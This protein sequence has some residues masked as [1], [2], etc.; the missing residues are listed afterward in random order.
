MATRVRRRPTDGQGSKQVQNNGQRKTTQRRDDPAPLIP[1]LARRVREVESRVSQQGQG[2][3]DEPNEV[4]R[5][6]PAHAL[7]ARP[8]HARTPRSRRRPAPTC[9][10]ASTA[11][12]R[13]SRRSRPGTRA[14]STLLDAERQ[15]RS[16]RAADAPRLAPRVGRRARR[17]G[18]R[19]HGPRAAATRRPGRR[20]RPGRSCRSRC[21][22]ARSPT[23]S[24][25]P[26]SAA[27]QQRLPPEPPRRLG[28]AQP[29]LPGLRAGRRRRGRLDGP[30][31][32]RRRSTA[33][34]RPGSQ[35]MVH[36]SRFLE[37]VREGHRTFL[38]ADE[39]G[40]GKTAQSVLA[41]SVADA[42]PMLAV[43]PNVVKINW[44]REVERWTPQRRVTVIH[45]DGD[46]VDA[47]ADVF[48]VNYEILDRHF[49]VARRRF[50]FRSMVVDE[51][52]FIKN[53]AS[54]RSQQVLA[55]GDR[56][57]ASTPVATRSCSPSPARRSSTT[58][59]TS[60]RSGASSAGSR[61]SKPAAE[62]LRRARRHR[63]HARRPRLLPRGPRAPSSTWGSCAAARSMSP[64]TCPTSAS[65]TS[66][67]SSTTSSAAR[68]AR[69]SGPSGGASPSATGPCSAR[70]DGRRGGRRARRRP[71]C[72]GS[73]AASCRADARPRRAPTTSSRW[74]ASIGQAKAA[75]AADYAVQLS[76]SV[77]K[78]VFFAKHIDVMDAAERVLAEAGLR[79]V[80]VRGDQTTTAAPGGHRRVPEG[81]RASRSRSA[82]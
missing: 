76:H 34:R 23:R 12:R 35:L 58:S 55:L 21:P 51:A 66:P 74:C 65:P 2:Q 67:S 78:V 17:G 29:A 14:C 45:G 28:P 61:A 36:Q 7:G 5:R 19:H 69:P 25:R 82:R 11:S 18:P 22:R 9:S 49:G 73:R 56:L 62:I 72:A 48:V 40:L 26:T 8:G 24:S 64:R 38:L 6:G 77:G 44:A 57:R 30:A 43:V 60:T 80:S 31:A 70:G 20:S 42:Y 81:P 75:L 47:F 4:P 59:R 53:L 32:R 39:P 46:D 37:S 79:T 15:A 27:C 16:R 41:A 10:S 13:S 52:H 50:G 63:P 54:Q 68:S 3:P 1:V 71:R 33:S